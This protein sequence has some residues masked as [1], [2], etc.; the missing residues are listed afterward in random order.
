MCSI[1]A[2]GADLVAL[3]QKLVQTEKARRQAELKT[4][5]Q[6]K[7]TEQQVCMLWLRWVKEE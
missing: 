5:Q 3:K 1:A 2:G 7:D 6:M 4:A